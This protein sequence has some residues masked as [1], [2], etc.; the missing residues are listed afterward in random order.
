MELHA[1]NSTLLGSSIDSTPESGGHSE[2]CGLIENH[3][4]LCK[5]EFKHKW[6]DQCGS[7]NEELPRVH[8][9][10]C[11]CSWTRCM[12]YAVLGGLILIGIG[13][14][15]FPIFLVITVLSDSS[16]CSCSERNEVLRSDGKC[17]HK[18][19]GLV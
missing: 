6:D 9:F 16:S 5:D 18:L 7:C 3:C 11:C 19:C 2:A 12:W 10:H 8:P 4:Q 1:A 17:C 14:F 13:I 15:L